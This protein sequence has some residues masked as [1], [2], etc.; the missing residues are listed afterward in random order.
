M[1]ARQSPAQAY[2]STLPQTR[3]HSAEATW[4]RTVGTQSCNALPNSSTALSQRYAA[5]MPQG[6]AAHICREAS[7]AKEAQAITHTPQKSTL[8]NVASCLYTW[9]RRSCQL[10]LHRC[11]GNQLCILH[12]NNVRNPCSRHGPATPKR[13]STRAGFEVQKPTRLKGRGACQQ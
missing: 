10:F 13:C 7:C 11:S 12:G 5:H 3:R 9:R 2:P 6:R 8:F 4:N 1:R